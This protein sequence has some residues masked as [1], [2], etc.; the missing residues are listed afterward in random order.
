MQNRHC[1]QCDIHR[2]Q[3]KNALNECMVVTINELYEIVPVNSTDSLEG[4]DLTLVY[5][6]GCSWSGS[7]QSLR[8][9]DRK[10]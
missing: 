8:G 10:H 2:F 3:V 4:F 5:C 9:R 7:P 1:P 6:L